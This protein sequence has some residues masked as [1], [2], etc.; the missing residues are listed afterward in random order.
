[1][2]VIILTYKRPLEEVLKHLPAHCGY[3]DR[4]YAAGTFVCSGPQLPR[5]GGVI[6]CRAVDRLAV[7]GLILDDPFYTEG[8]ADYEVIEFE[9][10]HFAPNFEPFL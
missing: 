1:M 5:T 9:V 3:L 4:H 6:L 8:I 10:N 2:F 7:D